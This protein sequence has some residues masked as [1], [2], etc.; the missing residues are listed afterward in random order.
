MQVAPPPG[1][2]D[3]IVVGDLHGQLHDL[4]AM[5]AGPGGLWELAATRRRRLPPP[6]PSTHV[7][8]L[9]LALRLPCPAA[10]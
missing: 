7:P 9:R 6:A 3:V 8:P 2:G 1:G 10:A 4:L 5:C